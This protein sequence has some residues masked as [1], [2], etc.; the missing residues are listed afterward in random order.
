[1]E[2]K[3]LNRAYLD[4]WD[5]LIKVRYL[6][7]YDKTFNEEVEKTKVELKEIIENIKTALEEIEEE[8]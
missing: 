1:M 8:L 2:L 5:Y 7:K 3:N 6:S 4:K